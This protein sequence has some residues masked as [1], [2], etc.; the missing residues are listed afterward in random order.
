MRQPAA[1]GL[2]VLLCAQPLGCATIKAEY[3][4]R[5]TQVAPPTGTAPGDVRGEPGQRG[6]Y[7]DSLMEIDVLLHSNAVTLSINNRGPDPL[8]IIWDDASFVGPDGITGKVSNGHV[9]RIDLN[10]VQAPTMIPSGRTVVVHAVPNR[11]V[12][13]GDFDFIFSNFAAKTD[14]AVGYVG[15]TME[16]LLPVQ[17]GAGAVGEYRIVLAIE[18]RPTS[19]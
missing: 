14:E 13:Q 10:R 18:P 17:V 15:R 19:R 6:A 8:R 11:M 4:I 7:S 12:E 9:P 2:M 16:L 3:P 5:L 1:L